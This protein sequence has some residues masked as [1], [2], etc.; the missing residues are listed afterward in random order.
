MVVFLPGLQCE[1]DDNIAPQ[2]SGDG[3]QFDPTQQIPEEGFKF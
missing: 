1:E 3:F 2:Q